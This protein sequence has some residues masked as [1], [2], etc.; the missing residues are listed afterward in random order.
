MKKFL[1]LC[2]F[3]LA[4]CTAP[5]AHA[6]FYKIHNADIS[7]SAIGQFPY[8]LTT[9]NSNIQQTNTESFGGLF[10]I[11]EHPVSWAGVEVNYAYTDFSEKFTA[12]SYTARTHTDMHE[13]TAAYIF[14]AHIRHFQ[15]FLAVGGGALD[16]V[17]RSGQNQ[18]RGTGLVE[19]GFDIPTSN[20][21]F[22]FR[23]QGR[24]LI[25]RAPNFQQANLASRSWVGTS[26]PTLGAWY[27]F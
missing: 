24:E 16:F 9:N 5:M 26:E 7:G 6:Q 3:T 4:A 19:V 18:W 27:R 12:P 1:P 11:K 17:P 2:A 25:Y 15:P 14:H 21:H 20:P 13:A 23:V 8:T 22:G 10:S